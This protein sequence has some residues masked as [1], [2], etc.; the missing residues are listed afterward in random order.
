VARLAALV[1]A[2]T[3]VAE[4]YCRRRFVT[5]RWRQT[6]DHFPRRALVLAHPPLVSVESVAYVDQGGIIQTLEPAAYVARAGETPGEVV[7]SYGTSW[8]STRCEED[9]V[10]VDFTCGYGGAAAVP[11]AIKQAVLLTMAVL[12]DD[13]TSEMPMAAKALLGPFRVQR[14]TA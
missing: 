4:A 6:E 10:R 9:A 3:E 7:P 8:P 12:Y 13:P 11:A 14:F 2:A 1:A 5:Q